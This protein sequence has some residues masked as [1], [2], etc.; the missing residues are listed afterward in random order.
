MN[1]ADIL[2]LVKDREYLHGWLWDKGILTSFEGISCD[3]EDCV[4]QFVLRKDK[5]RIH[6]GYRWKCN[7]KKCNRSINLR[8]KS[9]FSQSKLSMGDIIKLTYLWVYKHTNENIKHEVRLG[10]DHTVVDWKN[11]CREVCTIIIESESE[12]IG[13]EGKTVEIDESKFGKRKFHRGRRVDGIWVFGGIERETNRVF[14]QTVENRSADTLV[15]IIVKYVAKNT[16]IMSDCWRAYSQLGNMGY[17]HMTVNHS[18]EFVDSETGACT[19]KIESTWRAVK[20][21]L[22]R[23][24]T[25]KGLYNTYFAEYIIRKKYLNDSED[26][27][28]AFL[29]LISRVFT[30][31]GYYFQQNAEAEAVPAV[32][33]E[34]AEEMEADESVFDNSAD[35]FE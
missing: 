18:K 5:S 2:D 6:D 10:S 27:F 26:K 16:T 33:D 11:F 20:A 23:F 34:A 12:Q 19:N 24:G 7:Q 8:H 3:K 29:G 30:P 9:W 28:I 31:N 1:Y 4:G 22:P 21:S 25:Q 32:V 17:Q 13:G 15:P 14:M 35:L